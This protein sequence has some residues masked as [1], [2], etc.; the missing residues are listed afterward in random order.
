MATRTAEEI[1]RL[2]P[3]DSATYVLLSNIHA[4]AKRWKDVSKVRTTMR[5]RNVKKEPGLSWLEVK[6]RVFQFSM[7]DKSLPV[8]EEID[9]YLKELMEEMKSRGYVPDTATIFHDTD[10]EEKENSLVNHSEKLAIAF[11]LMNIPPGL[12]IRVMKNLRIC[13]DCHVA[14][15]LISDIKNREIIVRDTSRFHH[16]KHGKCSC[17]DYWSGS[18]LVAYGFIHFQICWMIGSTCPGSKSGDKETKLRLI[19]LLMAFFPLGAQNQQDAE[20][21]TE[22]TAVLVLNFASKKGE[23]YGQPERSWLYKTC[24]ADDMMKQWIYGFGIEPLPHY[25][26]EVETDKSDI[27]DSSFVRFAISAISWLQNGGYQCFELI[28]GHHFQLPL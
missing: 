27:T 21:E 7:G 20:R 14:I 17:G 6:N 28:S 26:L 2:N 4:S 11:G 8:S 16:F 1:L 15:K 5:D 10:S 9:L 12:P 19:L 22:D 18:D 25:P 24:F 13:S 23:R 3:Q